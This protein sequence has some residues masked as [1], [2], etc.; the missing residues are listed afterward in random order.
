MLMQGKCVGVKVAVLGH[1][2][3]KHSRGEEN[4]RN[5]RKWVVYAWH[6]EILENKDG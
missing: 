1:K 4:D 6:M 2:D 3:L 5:Y